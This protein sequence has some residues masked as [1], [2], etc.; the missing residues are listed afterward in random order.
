MGGARRARVLGRRA[1]RSRSGRPTPGASGW[2]ATSPAGARTTA[3]RCG[4][5]GGSGVWEIFVPGATAGQPLQVPD[6]RRRRALAGQG[7]PA[8]RAHRGAAGHRLGGLPVAAT[9]G[10]TPTGSPAGRSGQ[11]HQEP[12]SVYEV[13]LGSWRPGLGYRELAD[14]LTEYVV[15]LGFTHVEFLPVMEHPFG[16][17]W[18]YQVTGYYAPTAR[19]G[20]PDEFRHLVDRLHQAGIGVMLDWVPAHFPAR[21]VGA[22]PLRRH[23]ALR[24]PRPAPR[25]APR[26]GHVRLRLRPP[27]GAQL[28]GR[29]RALLVRRVPRRRAAGGRGRLDALPRLLP[30]G[31]ASG[32][33][34]STAAGRTWR[35]SRSSRR[36]TRPS[37]SSTP[38]W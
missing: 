14:Q 23:P 37:T 3:G 24:A 22:G 25:R 33:P 26:L 11:P 7:R 35:R 9:T 34:T 17:S 18:G 15:E 38:A 31:R 19:F 21:R 10:R 13:H 29:Q 1:C 28:P 4:R 32:R 2:S 6:P 5:S 36:S 16:G 12:M 27:R 30:Q 20:D 8:R